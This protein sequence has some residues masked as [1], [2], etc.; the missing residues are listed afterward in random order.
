MNLFQITDPET[1]KKAKD[2]ISKFGIN[3]LETGF[4]SFEENSWEACIITEAPK[5][6]YCKIVIEYER[7]SYRSAYLVHSPDLYLAQ[8]IPTMEAIS[9][10]SID[11]I[12]EALFELY[13][14]E[15]W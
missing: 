6:S 12:K 7:D 4:N 13:P 8:S 9:F 1:L 10:D 11:K 3:N 15:E 2:F 14:S 5:E